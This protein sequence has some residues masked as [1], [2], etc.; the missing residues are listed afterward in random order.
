MMV[1]YE[2][3]QVRRSYL[4]LKQCKAC[5]RSEPRA[6]VGSV[7]HDWRRLFTPSGVASSA[8]PA[9]SLITSA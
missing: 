6:A 2:E 7:N 3:Q 1:M 4:V 5:S 9:P 8:Y